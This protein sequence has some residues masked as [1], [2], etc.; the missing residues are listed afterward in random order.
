MMNGW[1]FAVASNPVSGASL[2]NERFFDPN[3]APNVQCGFVSKRRP[4]GL[5]LYLGVE[6]YLVIKFWNFD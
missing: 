5:L 4:Q 6:Y 2:V 1:R 3:A